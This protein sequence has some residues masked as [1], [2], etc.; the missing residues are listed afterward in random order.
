MAAQLA[1]TR[2]H[3]IMWHP[4]DLNMVRA[5]DAKR[6]LLHRS[7]CVCNVLRRHAIQLHHRAWFTGQPMSA[8]ISCNCLLMPNPV[9]RSLGIAVAHNRNHPGSMPARRCYPP[10]V[11]VSVWL[12]K[13]AFHLRFPRPYDR[14][15]MH[16]HRRTDRAI[17]RYSSTPALIWNRLR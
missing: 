10:W 14:Q 8:A 6:S 12:S 1:Y 11:M 17:A 9:A 13:P 7:P 4:V 15:L 2:L 16:F 5:A 3:T